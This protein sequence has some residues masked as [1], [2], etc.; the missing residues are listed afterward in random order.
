MSTTRPHPDRSRRLV[1]FGAVSVAL[2][3]TWS[4]YLAMVY[5]GMDVLGMAPTVAYTTAGVFELSLVTVALLAREAAKTNRPGGTLLTLTWLLSGASGFFAGWHELYIGHPLGAAIFRFL[6]PLLAALMWHLAL[7]GDRHLASGRTWSSMRQ[8]ARMHALF[9]S[10][11]AERRAR[12][13][14]DGRRRSARR[15]A[16]AERRRLRARAVALRTVPPDSMR[17]Q[18]ATWRDALSAVDEGAA[19]AVSLADSD[20]ARMT[21]RDVRDGRDV[22]VTGV[23]DDERIVTV[24]VPDA[25]VLHVREELDATDRETAR[26]GLPGEGDTTVPD[27]ERVPA[28][29]VPDVRAAEGVQVSET[30]DVPDAQPAPP[31]DEELVRMR[32]SGMSYR[33]IAK[34]AGLAHS[35][36]EAR[37][38]RQIMR[39]DDGPMNVYEMAAARA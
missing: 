28:V 18:V 23:L 37:I 25:Q 35:T 33:R 26:R 19:E 24:S 14:D 9:L 20:A 5:F 21:A 15:I 1:L 39:R 29:G 36:V 7:I 31:T 22:Q 16:R 2:I 17:A 30:V 8:G 10:I 12:R 11:D 4:A 34:E 27:G 32:R 3:S 13:A 38:K 6:V